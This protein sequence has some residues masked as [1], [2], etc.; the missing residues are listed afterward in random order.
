M[1]DDTGCGMLVDTG[2]RDTGCRIQD[3]EGSRGAVD[4]G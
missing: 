3:R 4:A 2:C 1:I